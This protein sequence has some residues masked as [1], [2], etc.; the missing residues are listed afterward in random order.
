MGPS[1]RPPAALTPTPRPQALYTLVE[2]FQLS[3]RN[4]VV[5][6][7]ASLAQLP[8]AIFLQALVRGV[9]NANQAPPLPAVEEVP[10]KA[11][12]RH[13]QLSFA[14]DGKPGSEGDQG[15]N[16]DGGDEEREAGRRESALSTVEEE[17]EEVPRPYLL[18]LVAADYNRDRTGYITL[19]PLHVWTS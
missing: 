19:C 14:M 2:S 7:L 18:P 3:A 13:R 9:C 17:A 6:F 10:V 4:D 8:P 12:P 5:D 11:R 16:R 15:Q 1:G